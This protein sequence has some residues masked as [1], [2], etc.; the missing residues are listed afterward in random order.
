MTDSA[1]LLDELEA[2]R[3]WAQELLRYRV[4]VPFG[5][6][7]RWSVV[8]VTCAPGDRNMAYAAF[9]HEPCIEGDYTALTHSRSGLVMSDLG[10][11]V[12]QSMPIIE[13]GTGRVLIHGLGLGMVVAALLAKPDVTSIDV[14]ERERDVIKLVAPSYVDPRLHLHHGD[15]LTFRFPPGTRWDCAWHDIWPT[16]DR[17]NLPAMRL[18]HRRYGHRVGWQASWGRRRCEE[19][20]RRWLHGGMSCRLG[21]GGALISTWMPPE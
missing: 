13:R 12:V 11:E 3:P 6:S 15:A 8:P 16:I 14:V 7:G 21:P 1:A 5:R 17:D 9:N 2:N 10:P 20:R 4:T 19:A 18:L